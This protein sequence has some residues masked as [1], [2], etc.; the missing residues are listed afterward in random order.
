MTDST[1]SLLF[2]PI[3][4]RGVRA[5]NRV[6]VS[7]MCM[8][9]SVNGFASDYHMVHLGRFALGGAGIV[10]AEATAVAPEG[11]ISHQDLGIWDDAH[12]QALQP[13]TRFLSEYGAV[14]GI[15]LA[16]AGRKAACHEPW[17][18]GGPLQPEDAEHGQAP[19]QSV[20]PSAVA[21]GPTWQVPRELSIAEIQQSVRDWGAAARCAVAAG[22]RAIELHGAHG[23]L[24]HSFQS[25]ISNLRTDEYGGSDHARWRYP[26]EVVEA[27]RAEIPDDIP[28]F[29]RVSSVDRVDDGITIDDTIAFARELKAKGV[30]V[31]DTSSGGI[32]T[33]RKIDTRVRRGYGF[34]APLAAELTSALRPDGLQIA[35]VGM[36]VDAAQAEAMLRHDDADIVVLGREMLANPAW[37][38]QARLELEGPDFS[39]MHEQAASFMDHRYR[40]ITKLTA[41]GESPLDRHA[42]SGSAGQ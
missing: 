6:M 19:W 21:A 9:S 26:L 11:R 23:Y 31:I 41:E 30:D 13:I 7:P 32:V 3:E 1:S 5:R 34:H 12:I 4:L 8:Y 29:Y 24:L 14:P 17:K 2:T 38:N 36:I 42:D 16:H 22:F 15:Q 40:L 39:G 20:G 27:I 10:M 35:N 33:D 37:A 28:L 18:G 25:P